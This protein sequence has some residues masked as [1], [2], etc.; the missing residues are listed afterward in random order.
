MLFVCTV[1]LTSRDQSGGVS[2]VESDVTVTTAQSLLNEHD[3]QQLPD[4]Y[5]LMETSNSGC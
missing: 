1:S 2:M 3:E 5:V 4:G